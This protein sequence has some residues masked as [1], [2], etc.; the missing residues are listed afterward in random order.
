MAKRIIVFLLLPLILY[1]AC[2]TSE[3]KGGGGLEPG[4]TDPEIIEGFLCANVFEGRPVGI[5]NEFFVDDVIYIWLSW[6]NVSGQHELKVL[7]VD[8]NDKTIEAT[9]TF[10]SKTGKM[11]TYMWLDTSL[12]AP[13]G[14]WVAEV[15][16]DNKFV[17]SYGFWLNPKN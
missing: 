9:S 10:E 1:L 6:V 8:P 12:T 5:D 14:K 2:S 3:G 7:W 15:Y 16:L 17:R 4:S 13:T 11:V